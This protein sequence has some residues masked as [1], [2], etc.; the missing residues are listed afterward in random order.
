MANA[1]YSELGIRRDHVQRKDDAMMRWC[2]IATTCG[3]AGLVLGA[4][5]GMAVANPPKSIFTTIDLGACKI[6]HRHPDGN[7]FSCKGLPGYPV[8]YG[9]GD[10]RAFVSVGTHSQKQKRKAQEQTLGPFNTVFQGKSRR[11]TLE[12]RVHSDGEKMIPHATILRYYTR[13][14]T[15]RGEVLVIMHV[16]ERETC[17]AGIID[18]LAESE[19]MALAR[20]IADGPART[21]SCQDEPVVHG[22]TG[23][24]PF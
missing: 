22:T 14:E 18:A 17:Q 1:G 16:G 6:V 24:S 15:G 21:F 8:V 10:L 4:G 20:K 2:A 3:L 9:E 7:T 13:N 12:W 11:A 19:A 5:A 23:K